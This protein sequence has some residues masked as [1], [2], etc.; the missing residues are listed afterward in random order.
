MNET[1][2]GFSGAVDG[3]GHCSLGG[4]QCSPLQSRAA[5]L[6]NWGWQSV[7]SINQLACTRSGS[8]HGFNSETG[9]SCSEKWQR[10]RSLELSLS[11]VFDL[12]RDFHRS[13]PFLFLNGNSISFIGREL[14][15]ALFS[16]LAPVRKRELASAVAHYIAGVLDR[17]SMVS[18]VESLCESAALG[19]GDRAQ[20][21]RG[22]TSGMVV[23]V[24]DDGRV[25][26]KPDGSTTEFTERPESLTR[27]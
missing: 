24:L 10:Q 20:T 3:G 1:P 27:A 4:E 22:S 5:F 26:W 17:D 14:S 6:K 8:Q 25:V 9:E 11:E 18:I 23:R 12:L 15:L 19:P 13:A 21:L 7:A 2:L 16:D